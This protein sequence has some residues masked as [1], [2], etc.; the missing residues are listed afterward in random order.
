MR[1]KGIRLKL[2]AEEMSVILHALIDLR[3]KRLAEGKT[4]Y[5]IN[6]LILKFA[7]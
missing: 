2:T 3:N 4:V 7:D 6:D 5:L 1:A